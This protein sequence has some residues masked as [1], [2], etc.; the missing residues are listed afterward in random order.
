MRNSP[1]SIFARNMGSITSPVRGFGISRKGTSGSAGASP[2]AFFSS[3]STTF[4]RLWRS[5]ARTRRELG[6]RP[7]ISTFRC[8]E[9]PS[10]RSQPSSGTPTSVRSFGG[11][12][13]LWCFHGLIALCAIPCSSSLVSLGFIF[14]FQARVVTPPRPS[15]LDEVWGAGQRPPAMTLPSFFGDNRG[16]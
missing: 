15:L 1:R 7:S 5:K 2:T 16:W 10:G 3:L 13:R 8:S 11:M 6:G 14:G 12:I 9:R 4:S